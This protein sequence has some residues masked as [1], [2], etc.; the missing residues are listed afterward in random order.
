MFKNAVFFLSI[1]V[2]ELNVGC[3]NSLKRYSEFWKL[4]YDV[5][6]IFR[7]TKF[8]ISSPLNF[9]MSNITQ[10]TGTSNEFEVT[11]ALESETNDST[12]THDLCFSAEATNG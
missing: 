8:Y 4:C 3:Q 6:F 1:I 7:V 12:G 9:T 2:N 11:V 10:P 5:D